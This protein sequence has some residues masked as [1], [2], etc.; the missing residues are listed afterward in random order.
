MSISVKRMKK[1]LKDDYQIIDIRSAAEIAHGEIPGAVIVAP[2]NVLDN[3]NIDYSKKLIICCARGEKSEETA[4]LLQSEGY[5]AQSLEGGFGA[6]L[7][8]KMSMTDENEKAFEVEKSLRK[9]FRKEI[10]SKFTKAVNTYELVKPGDKIAVCISGGKDSM[11]M[12]KCFQELKLHDKF[13]FDVKFLAMDPGYSP[14]NRQVIEENA[15]ILNIPITV[16]ESDIFE[17]VYNIEKSPCYLCARMR[18]GH[19]YAYAKELGCN[20]I[21]LGH[22]Y[23]DVIETILMG[24]L[25]GAQVQTMMPKLHSTNFEGMEL[26]R[27]LYLVREDDIKAWRDYNGLNFIQCACK[28][29]DTCTTCNNEENQSK[30][31]EIKE[32]IKTLKQVNPHVESNIFRSVENVNIDTVIAYKQNGVKHNFLDE[33]DNK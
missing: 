30:R 33:Y 4:R 16:F 25:Y 24:M 13:D 8:D 10:W 20:K 6:W 1:L 28:F 23:D 27:P 5:D 18:R 15:R 12:A 19:L 2:E 22:H 3:K 14:R 29:T 31:V 26:I 7:L 21:A 9:K 11:L 32:L 17:S